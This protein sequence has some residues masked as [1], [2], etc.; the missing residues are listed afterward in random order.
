MRDIK[1]IL[2]NIDTIYGSN[3]ALNTLKDFERVLDE[4]D[5]YVYDNWI[6]GELAEG[7]V[8]SRYWVTCT[9]MW[10]YKDMPDPQG[11][12]RLLDF[13]CQ[14]AFTQD[15][16]TVVRKVK[17]PDD[18]RPGTK[19]GKVDTNKVWFVE[20]KIPKKLMFD[21]NKGY[22]DL[23]KNKIATDEIKLDTSDMLAEPAD[24]QLQQSMAGQ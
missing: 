17:T 15:E 11:G 24:Q 19:K 14:L 21:I 8:E 18:I 6:D 3:N 4:L 12:K 20:I 13:G 9:F 1:D 22:K 23:A 16:V 7:P 5:V 2:H 10:P